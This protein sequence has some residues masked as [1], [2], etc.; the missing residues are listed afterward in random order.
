MIPYANGS[1][2]F[3]S[4]TPGNKDM[5]GYLYKDSF[6]PFNVT[7]NLIISNDDGGGNFQ[8][9][10]T[11]YLQSN[12]KYILIVTT[13]G[14]NVITSYSVNISGPGNNITVNLINVAILTTTTQSMLTIFVL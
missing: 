11:A 10:I 3:R 5:Y 4:Y 6:N 9:L 8:F 14:S 2:T 7:K 12:N 13:F 1:F